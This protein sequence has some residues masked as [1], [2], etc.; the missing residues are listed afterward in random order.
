MHHLKFGIRAVVGAA[1]A[2]LFVLPLYWA[3]VASL[4]PIGAPPPNTIQWLPTSPQW[5]NY[6]FLFAYLPMWRYLG[7]SLRVVALAVP[8][9]ILTASM[10]GFAMS[11][12]PLGRRRQLLLFSVIWLIIPSAALWLFRFRIYTSLGLINSLWALIVPSLAAT[13]P[14]FVLLF[15]W[16]FRQIPTEMFESARLEG[17]GIWTLWWK[18]AMPLARPT[19]V[20]VAVLA[21]VFYWSDFIGPVL[22]LF[23]TSLYTM[24]IGLQLVNQLDRTNWPLLMTAAMVMSIPIILVFLFFQR[25]FLHDMSIANLFDRN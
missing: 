24:P 8:F 11:Q 14:L 23:S 2:G 19:I 3:A 6:P 21:F 10:A 4:G 17:A 13:N 20:A 16:G 15:Y 12:L 18:L 7:N 1:V 22:Y 5:G 9:T 25:I